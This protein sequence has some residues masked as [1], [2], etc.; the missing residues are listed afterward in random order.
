MKGLY[1]IFK[2]VKLLTDRACIR[3]CYFTTE[4]MRYCTDSDEIYLLKEGL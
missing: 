2:T 1:E 4:N 3:R